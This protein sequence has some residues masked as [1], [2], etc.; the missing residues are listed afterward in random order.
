MS[1]NIIYDPI[2]E[3][4]DME[5]IEV[6]QDLSCY[7]LEEISR[8]SAPVN[9]GIPM[10]DEQKKLISKAN[11]GKKYPN[12]TLSNKPIVVSYETKKKISDALLGKTPS[13]E[14]KHKMSLA[15][16]GKPKKK[17]VCPHCDKSVAPNMFFR[18]HGKK[19]KNI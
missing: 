9:K 3:A 14:T 13:D 18:W 2:A 17:Y 16:L 6:P 7:I 11:T 8:P 10:S 1:S 4:L 15:K 5:P 19:C 12:R